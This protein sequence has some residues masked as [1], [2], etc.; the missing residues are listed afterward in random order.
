MNFIAAM[1]LLV[2]EKE[3]NVFWMLCYV[4]EELLPGY[5]EHD[6]RGIA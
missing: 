3:H 5:Y 6:L 1:L 4:V 2:E